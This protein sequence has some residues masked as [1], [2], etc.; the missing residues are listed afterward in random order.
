MVETVFKILVIGII[1][2]VAVGLFGTIAFSWTLDTSPYL[3]SLSEILSIVFYIIPI[4]KISPII[5]CFIGLMAFRIIIA[6]ITTIWN[7]IPIHG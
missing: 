6:V 7:L 3:S 5:F 2:S 1:I 4:G